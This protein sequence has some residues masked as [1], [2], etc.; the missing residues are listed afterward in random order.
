MIQTELIVDSGEFLQGFVLTAAHVFPERQK[1]FN[2]HASVSTELVERQLSTF[3]LLNHERFGYVQ[4]VRRLTWR[5]VSIYRKQGNGFSVTKSSQ[6]LG[7]DTQGRAWDRYNHHVA[8]IAHEINV[9]SANSTQRLYD[10]P[11]GLF[12]ERRIA[13]G[14]F[15]QFNALMGIVGFR[16]TK[17]LRVHF[18]LRRQNQTSRQMQCPEQTTRKQPAK[19]KSMA[20]LQLDDEI[21]IEPLAFR[22][23]VGSTP[24]VAQG[25]TNDSS[26][27]TDPVVQKVVDMTVNPKVCPLDQRV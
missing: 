20:S 23:A 11:E 1:V 8:L 25:I 3:H 21:G 9:G 27:A 26:A 6:R 19:I 24:G 17:A 13:R 16:H 12:R 18:G 14:Q 22:N 7:D 2:R 5:H 10:M 4:E 15:G